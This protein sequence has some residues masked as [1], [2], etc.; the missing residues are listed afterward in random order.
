MNKLLKH[1]HIFIPCLFVLSL[2][3]GACSQS[4]LTTTTV[5]PITLKMAVLPI[6]DTL[7]MYVAQQEGLFEQ[8]GVG[9]TRPIGFR[10]SS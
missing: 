2:I 5:E 1:F 6:L 4:S 9:R 7:P 3:V 8:N 10:W